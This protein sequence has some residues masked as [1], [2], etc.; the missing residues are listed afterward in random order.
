MFMI[1]FGAG[2]AVVRL[3]KYVLVAFI[4]AMLAPLI[5]PPLRIRIPGLGSENIV[6]M[7][8]RALEHLAAFLASSIYSAIG[9]ILGVALALVL[10]LAGMKARSKGHPQ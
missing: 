4:A 3:W 9:F 7:L 10:A 6:N 5:L 8:T 2:L 1:G